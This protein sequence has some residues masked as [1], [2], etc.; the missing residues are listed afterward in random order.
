MPTFSYTV[1]DS[2]GSEVTGTLRA[3]DETMAR[4][5][6]EEEG[7]RL[8]EIE[9]RTSWLSVE[10]RLP[11]DRTIGLRERGL[12]AR[13]L[14]TLLDAGVPL[15]RALN[16]LEEQA[17]R[18]ALAGLLRRVARDVEAGASLSE[19]LAAHP[20]A[21]DELFVNTVRAGEAGGVLAPVLERLADMTETHRELRN[22]LR[23]A[24]LYPIVLGCLTVGVVI[25]LLTAVLPAFTTLY[26]EMGVPLPVPTRIMLAGGDFVRRWW[27]LLVLVPAAGWYGF[28][29]YY[30]TEAGRDRLDR[31]LLRVP[32]F[33][34]LVGSVAAARFTRTLG[35]LLE[36]GVPLLRAMDIVRDTLGNRAVTNLMD[37]VIESVRDGGTVSGPLYESDAFEPMVAHMI[38]VGERTGELPEVLHRIADTSRSRVETRVKGLSSL[39]EP[40][41]IVV[42]GLSVGMIVLAMYVPLFR[43]MQ[44]VG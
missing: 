18:Q 43:L 32:L 44:V 16:I 22:R 15:L 28:R 1:L 23:S 37:E 21:F 33:G 9:A 5:R 26:R 6:L 35:S 7:Y 8:L 4:R 27:Y 10:V 19:A 17:G 24:A 36:N 39:L 34:E 14:A 2:G 38:A 41:L 42:L 11:W 29:S 3:P 25:F 30:G 12:L 31:L 20:Q 40:L 13:Q